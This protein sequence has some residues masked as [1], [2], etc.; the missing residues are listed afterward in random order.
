MLIQ[1]L[2]FL[3]FML[4]SVTWVSSSD[5][6]DITNNIIQ[7]GHSDHPDPRQHIDVALKTPAISTK[8][9]SSSSAI[10]SSISSANIHATSFYN[11]VLENYDFQKHGFDSEDP[12]YWNALIN[13]PFRDFSHQYPEQA[14][15][16][17]NKIVLPHHPFLSQVPFT[18]QITDFL[19]QFIPDI[20]FFLDQI[21]KNIFA[22]QFSQILALKN[23][24]EAQIL[25]KALLHKAKTL[26]CYDPEY[27][28]HHAFVANVPFIYLKS[29]HFPPPESYS[30]ISSYIS[31]LGPTLYR[32]IAEHS[33]AQADKILAGVLPSLYS[34][35]TCT[36]YENTIREYQK[37]NLQPI[38]NS[39][40]WDPQL[41]SGDILAALQDPINVEDTHLAPYL[42][43]LR[44]IS[45][46]SPL[47]H[48][49]SH[50]IAQNYHKPS[51]LEPERLSLFWGSLIF[52]SFT[53]FS[54]ILPILSSEIF[55]QIFQSTDQSILANDLVENQFLSGF[56]FYLVASWG[57]TPT[58][59]ILLQ[60]RTD[61][62][63]DNAGCALRTA[64]SGGH[65]PIVKILLD[66]RTDILAGNAG[67]ALRS[68]AS[69]GH[70]PIVEILLR[71]TDI[72]AFN[73]GEALKS[74]A[75]G[76]YTST[77]DIILQG[78]TDIDPRH[79]QIAHQRASKSG[80]NETVTA[81]KA[82]IESRS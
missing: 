79:L 66:C 60:R 48:L 14:Q 21:A 67:F 57:H 31:Q 29:T 42:K 5:I 1:Y 3:V 73:A 45:Q 78:R 53:A 27:K 2:S 55:E 64:A 20:D 75:F 36:T 4:S 7:I 41:L 24:V 30:D 13:K 22:E 19:D 28:Y 8:L 77:V 33:Q 80:H 38:D 10:L 56:Y 62:S 47:A 44:F 49:Y 72:S 16:I 68:A 12:H 6:Q 37:S 9:G 17:I 43:I 11:F 40:L 32:A 63:A 35:L 23:P 76:G 15:V 65:T 18:F 46:D 39:Y 51:N 50:Y 58:V 70:T 26:V 82:Y 69:G 34:N 74:A 59:E 81:L 71:R 25:F 61:I 52:S 54:A